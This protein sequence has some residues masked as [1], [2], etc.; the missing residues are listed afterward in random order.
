MDRV[1]IVRPHSTNKMVNVK[2]SQAS[3]RQ[4]DGRTINCN[5]ADIG[6]ALHI[7][8]PDV[9]CETQNDF[10]VVEGISFLYF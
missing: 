6:I 2:Q 9:S 4:R 7:F 5:V 1:D 3:F 8:R 10:L